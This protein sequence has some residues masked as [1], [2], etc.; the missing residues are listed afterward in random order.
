[1]SVPLIPVGAAEFAPHERLDFSHEWRF[2][3]TASIIPADDRLAFTRLSPTIL[4]LATAVA[5]AGSAATVTAP[6]G[7]MPDVSGSPAEAA[8]DDAG[9]RRLDLPHDW[10]IEGPFDI[11]AAGETGKLPWSGVGWYRKRFPAIKPQPGQQTF[12]QI[13]GAMSCS[14]VWLNGRL[15]GGWAYGYTSWRVDLTAALRSDGDNVLAIRLENPPDS[16][17]W[18]PGGGIYRQV[19]LLTSGPGAIAA[20]GI[21]VSTLTADAERAVLQVGAHLKA[22]EGLQG[23]LEI[24]HALTPMGVEG[25]VA[26]VDVTSHF[27]LDGTSGSLFTGGPLVVDKP[28]LWSP[29]HPQL[30]QLET[31][32]TL[33]GQL[34]DRVRTVVGIRTASFTADDGFQ[35]NGSR[36]PIRGV[37]LHHDLGALGAAF[38]VRAAERQLQLLKEVGCNAIRTS[39]NPPAPE[40]LELC[41]RLGFLVMD[42][43]S[44]TWTIAKK[45]NGYARFF[46]EWSMLDVCSMVARDR[47]HP[48]VVLWSIGNEIGEQK[49]ATGPAIAER[50]ADAIRQMDASRQVAVGCDQ[51]VAGYNGF[52]T[53][54]DVFGYNYK[55]HEYTKFHQYN[56]D[57]PLIGSETSSCVSSRGV[58]AFPVSNDQAQGTVGFQVSSYDLYAPGWAMPPDTEFRGLD[59]APWV[60]GEFVWTGFDYLGEPT[61]FNKDL[62]VLTNFHTPEETAKAAAELKALGRLQVPSRSSYFGIFDLAGFRKDRF[63]LYQSRWRPDLPMGHLLPHWTWPGREGQVTPVHVYTSGDAAELFLNGRSLGRKEKRPGDYRLRWDEVVYEPGTLSVVAERRG[64]RWAESSV[65]TAGAAAALVL[66]ADRPAIRGDGRDLGFITIGVVDAAGRTVPEAAVPFSCTIQGPGS[67]VATDNGDPTDLTTFASPQ[68]KTFSGAGLV[69]IR[70]LPNGDQP[71]TVT[72]TAP[73]LPAATLTLGLEKTGE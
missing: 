16:S 35:L 9:W 4:A 66:S 17:R 44:D 24:I 12:L 31:R 51:V 8:F 10:G 43:F 19:W 59:E 21:T 3:K 36:V 61:P 25:A 13:D 5:T 63:Y 2:A 14:S 46:A 34:V 55:P 67:V 20:D 48:S 49:T 68:R 23:E 42:E 64:Q 52:Q 70:R 37:C 30:Y 47:N 18:Y 38:N 40:F 27:M 28:R 72:V 56:T 7:S 62:T 15:M 32:V 33:A 41:D 26:Q 39:H 54:V 22:L 1:M 11:Q 53:A 45:P 50:L 58:Y 29:D 69:I 6:A 73:G 65:T 71:V 60:A 57:L